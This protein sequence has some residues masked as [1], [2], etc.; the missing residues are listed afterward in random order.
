ML[1]LVFAIPAAIAAISALEQN[2][3]RTK[4]QNAIDDVNSGRI[5][6]QQAN[7]KIT[8][9]NTEYVNLIVSSQPDYQPRAIKQQKQLTKREQIF[10][11][12]NSGHLTEEQ[13]QW[14]REN[15]QKIR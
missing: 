11:M 15:N 6:P 12:Y 7:Q 5:S 4:I 13:M 10:E 1:P 8:D 3:P 14:F 2:H 9:A